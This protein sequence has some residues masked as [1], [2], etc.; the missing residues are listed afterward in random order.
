MLNE[1]AIDRYEVI[2]PSAQG[3]SKNDRS[4]IK[5]WLPTRF[6]EKLTQKNPIAVFPTHVARRISTQRSCFTVH[7]WDF[8]GLERLERSRKPLLRK[9][10][11]SSF[12]VRA[13]K[14]ELINSGIDEATIFPDLDGL[15][16][17]VGAEYAEQKDPWPHIRVVTK[18]RPSKAYPGRVGVFAIANI[19]SGDRPFR[20]ENEE[21]IWLD[22]K[23][24]AEEHMSRSAREFYA[25]FSLKRTGR[26]GC[27]TS[28]NRL[29][30]AWYLR[31]AKAGA[32][33][34]VRPDR[35]YEFY[36]M[37]NIALGEELIAEFSPV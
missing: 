7:G 6:K 14:R 34:N 5:K 9:L 31:R 32:K 13:I 25:E 26:L 37:R 16:R 15:G 8:R 17:A 23:S 10:L 2:P 30:P 3:V 18:L 1:R 29:T 11:I 28:F 24:I 4:R 12:C 27:P 21:I 22:K 35:Y 19:K 20:G 36:A 33:A